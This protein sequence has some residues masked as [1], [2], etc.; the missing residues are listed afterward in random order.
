MFVLFF[1][2]KVMVGYYVKCSKILLVIISRQVIENLIN[3]I[4]FQE[5]EIIQGGEIFSGYFCLYLIRDQ[6]KKYKICFKNCILYFCNDMFFLNK[7]YFIKIG[8][9][10]QLK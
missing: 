4:L 3:I 5:L 2:V 7:V 9:K 1:F 8:Y 10:M 6:K